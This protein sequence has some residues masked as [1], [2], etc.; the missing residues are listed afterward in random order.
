MSAVCLASCADSSSIPSAQNGPANAADGG[1]LDGAT[2]FV[3]GPVVATGNPPPLSGGTLAITADDRFAVASDPDGDRVVLTEIDT[4]NVRTVALS[5]GDEPGRVAVDDHGH[6]FVVLRRG[7][8]V[9]TV[10][11]ASGA[12]LARRDVCANPRGLVWDARSDS[13]HVACMDGEL[14]TLPA[15]EG[16]PTRRL[17]LADDLRDVLVVND[18]L[19]V[20]RFR[21]AA[22]LTVANDGTVRTRDDVGRAAP[23]RTSGLAW[24]TVVSGRRAWM[25]HQSTGPAPTI[26]VAVPGYYQTQVAVPCPG[27]E[28]VVRP[29]LTQLGDAPLALPP[30]PNAALAVD[31]DVSPDG[32][33]LALAIPGNHGAARGQ[34]VELATNQ[35]AC[36]SILRGQVV[37]EGQVVAVRYRRDGTLLAQTRAPTGLYLSN[38]GRFIPW[39]GPLIDHSGHRLFHTNPTGTVTCASCHAEGGDDGRVWTFDVGARRTP[40]LRGGLLG[41]EPFHWSGD[42]RDFRALVAEVMVRGMN[43]PTPD[44]A[45]ADALATWLDAQPA[46]RTPDVDSAS[47]ARGDA[48]FHSL[49]TGCGGC[50]AGAKTT[51]N[52]SVDVGT[53]GRFQVPSLRGLAARGPYLHNGCA[54]TLRDRL[55]T[56]GGGDRHGRTSQLTAGQRDDRVNHLRTL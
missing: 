4:G 31:L 43:A 32:T 20:T 55:S 46:H 3:P 35:P 33:R 48:I 22:V 16:S 38:A 13:L 54:A 52:Q 25:L 36:L 6:A 26:S 24:C 11:V 7:R 29:A 8:S 49:E 19:W 56:C 28:G 17:Q 23:A 47:A 18:E 40:H 1:A 12:V 45:H 39:G 37:A 41:T 14:V 15:G 30:V 53:G 21:S 34:L 51:N 2:S 10:D 27:L 44:A 5:A 50:H 42:L 9:V